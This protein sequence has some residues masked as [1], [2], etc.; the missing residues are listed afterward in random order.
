[1]AGPIDWKS[2][3]APSLADF[4]VIAASAWERIQPEFREVCGDLVIR[5]EDFALDEVLDELDIESPFDLMGLYQGLSLDKKSVLDVPRE[6]DMVFLYRRAILDYWTE[7][8]EETLGEII[9]HVLIHEIGH[10]FGFSDD[11]MEE[12]EDQATH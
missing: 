8:G 7:N 11:D 4:E 9:T 12:I 10:H 3:A 6:P 2:A 5:V 1:M